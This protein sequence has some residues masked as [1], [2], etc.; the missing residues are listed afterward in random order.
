MVHKDLGKRRYMIRNRTGLVL[1]NS[2]HSIRLKQVLCQVYIYL[3]YTIMLLHTSLIHR[4]EAMSNPFLSEGT[5]VN[6]DP[7]VDN[8]E[9]SSTVMLDRTLQKVGDRMDETKHTGD[10]MPERRSMHGLRINV[11]VGLWLDC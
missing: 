9:D 8:E 11:D 6:V 4:D 7:P 1:K 10:K 3:S 2:V 5:V